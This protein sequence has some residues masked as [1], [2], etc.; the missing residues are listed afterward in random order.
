MEKA[1]TT[2]ASPS[3]KGETQRVE[4]DRAEQTLTR[5]M[6]ESK[7]TVPHIYLRATIDMS[8]A[9]EVRSAFSAVAAAGEPVPSTADLVVKA[10]ALA[11]REHPRANGSYRD[12]GLELHS[13]VNIGV[14]VT[15]GDSFAVPTIVDADRLSLAE[16]ANESRRLAEEVRSGQATAAALSGGTF[17]I[18]DLGRFGV[19]DFDPVIFGGQAAALGL[20][21]IAERPVVRESGPGKAHLMEVALACDHRI[22]YGAGAATFLADIRRNLEEPDRLT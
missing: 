11:L 13:R 18:V 3:A 21:E 8:R 6:A 19:R 12:G 15:T 9:V 17:T 14:A 16:I 2:K 20:G 4:L 7:A 1:S 10:V 5:R 22:L